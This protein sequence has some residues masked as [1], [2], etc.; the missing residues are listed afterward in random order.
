MTVFA[1]L[2]KV[3]ENRDNGDGILKGSG[4]NGLPIVKLNTKKTRS[5]LPL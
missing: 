1:R 2:K 3:K 5:T 4:E